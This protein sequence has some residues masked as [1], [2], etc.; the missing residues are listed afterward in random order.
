MNTQHDT[1]RTYIVQMAALNGDI[2]TYTCKAE[3]H[4]AAAM[5][6]MQENEDQDFIKV[7]YT[8]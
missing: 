5:A 7:E 6:V 3:N 2:H 8:H 4:S 1:T